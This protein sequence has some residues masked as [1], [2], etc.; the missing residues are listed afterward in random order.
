M[1]AVY[2]TVENGTARLSLDLTD[3]TNRILR[4]NLKV[5]VY[6]VTGRK[7]STLKVKKG[8]FA[9]GRTPAFV[10]RGTMALRTPVSVGI[11]SFD[12]VEVLGGLDPGDE[13]I[14]SDMSEYE[15][16]STIRVH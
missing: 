14:I 15:H 7:D 13:V 9:D 12:E 4:P 5:D 11:A 1:S 8:P 3:S 10:I 16:L 6:L 2:P